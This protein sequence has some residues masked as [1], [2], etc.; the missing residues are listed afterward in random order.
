MSEASNVVTVQR[1]GPNIVTGELAVVMSARVREMKTAVLCRC[2]QSSDRPFCDGTH[3]T[4]GFSDPGRLPADVEAGCV[5]AGKVT[6]T[7]LPNGPN[8]CRGPLIVR[9]ADD[10]TCAFDLTYLC[11]CGGSQGKPF[12]DGTHARIG[13]IG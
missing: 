8:Q 2:G 13:F 1:N 5:G 10:S 12:C 4:I 9:G 3:V 6:I 7:P 11:R